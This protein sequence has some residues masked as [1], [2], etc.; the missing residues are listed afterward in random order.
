MSDVFPTSDFQRRDQLRRLLG[1]FWT[2][3]YADQDGVVR[4]LMELFAADAHD[5]AV[6]LEELEKTYSWNDCPVVRRHGWF[7]WI[8][9]ESDLNDAAVPRYG[10][11]GLVYEP[12]SAVAYGLPYLQSWAAYNAPAGLTSAL[13]IVDRKK[14]GSVFLTVDVDFYYRADDGRIWFRSDPFQDARFSPRAVFQNGVVSDRELTLWLWQADWDEETLWKLYGY[15]LSLRRPS[16]PAYANALGARLDGLLYGANKE[17]LYRAVEAMTGTPLAVGGETVETVA[18]DDRGL[19]VIT[20]QRVYRFA[21]AAEPLVAAGDVLHRGDSLTDAVEFF[22][23]SRG[24]TPAA[25][26]ALAL[27]ASFWG[28]PEDVVFVNHNVPTTLRRTTDG[29]TVSFPLGGSQEAVDAF[30]AAADAKGGLADALSLGAEPSPSTVP[31]VINPLK[32]LVENVL[33]FHTFIVR[34]RTDALGEDTVQDPQAWRMLIPP[35]TYGFLVVEMVADGETI[36]PDSTADG[37]GFFLP[38]AASDSVSPSYVTDRGRLF[39][40]DGVCG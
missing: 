29:Y 20:D 34:V 19:A 23:L 14:N 28:G 32:F 26:Q 9:K 16:T 25:L 5:L 39:S 7:P 36:G 8:I 38:I 35:H 2:R 33:R 15:M 31:A 12:G 6:R 4:R 17:N 22:D 10:D 18:T 27:P 24:V 21:A 13:G 40:L 37:G 1:G 3:F 11:A 30:W